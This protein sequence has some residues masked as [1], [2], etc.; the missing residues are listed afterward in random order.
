MATTRLALKYG[1]F[2]AMLAL[3]IIGSSLYTNVINPPISGNTNFA[4]MLTDPPNVP[5]GTTQLNVTYSD[6]QVHVIYSDG[7]SNWLAAQESDEINLLSLLNVTETIANLSLPTGSTVDKLQFTI[8]NCE[9]KINGVVHSVTIL[10]DKLVVSIRARKLNGT[11]TGAIIDLRPTLVQINARDEAGEIVSYYVLVPSATAI[12]KSN[13]A[14]NKMHVGARHQLGHDDND[15]LEEEFRNFSKHLEITSATLTVTGNKT[16][17][18]VVIKNTG[19]TN[20]TLSGL[21]LHGDFEVTPAPALSFNQGWGKQNEPDDESSSDHPRTIPF[22]ISG[23]KLIPVIDYQEYGNGKRFSKLELEPDQSVTLTFEG[24]IQLHPFI[25]G[26]G[27][28]IA[29]I[30][31]KGESYTIQVL[32]EGY[33]T[34]DVVVAP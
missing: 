12:V 16:L 23:D 4:V 6:I 21:T 7:S 25:F 28:P 22:K 3:V 34:F 11:N 26:K 31:I 1:F 13:V 19:T 18:T 17:L 30:P 27:K 5:R 10:T 32:G 20:A 29:I 15:E 8:S 14:A 24:V 9:A 2:A 33:Q